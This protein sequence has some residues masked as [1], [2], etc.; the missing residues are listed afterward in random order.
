MLK[1]GVN[2]QERVAAFLQQ[3][4]A[5]LAQHVFDE[6]TGYCVRCGQA[7]EKIV[8]GLWPCA[9]GGNVLAVSHRL[10]RRKAARWLAGKLKTTA[11]DLEDGPEAR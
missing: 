6:P 11:A 10:A 7:K 2:S 4:Q 3:V 8:N 1:H 5:R 9:G